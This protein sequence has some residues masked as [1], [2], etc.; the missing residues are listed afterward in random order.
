[1]LK[2]VPVEGESP[3]KLKCVI[4]K[5]KQNL[6]TCEN[7]SEDGL[8]KALLRVRGAVLGQFLRKKAIYHSLLFLKIEI[9]L[10]LLLSALPTLHC[11]LYF[12]THHKILLMI[13]NLSFLMASLWMSWVKTQAGAFSLQPKSPS[14]ICFMKYTSDPT[15]D[16]ININL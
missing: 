5:S 14:G 4:S 9:L 16:E 7:N 12:F 10:Y 3:E 1:M 2:S 15:K 6:N 11:S 8:K 13:L